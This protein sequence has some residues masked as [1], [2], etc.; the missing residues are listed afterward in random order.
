[1][2]FR[3]VVIAQSAKLDLRMNHLVVRGAEQT[4][5]IHLG[6]IG[7][8]VIESL[9]V[10]LTAALLA[11][12]AEKKIR[13]LFCD[14]QHS[15]LAEL[16]PYYARHDCSRKVRCQTTWREETKA[17]V[18]QRIVQAKIS[19]QADILAACIGED[20][21]VR[22]L[23]EYAAAVQ[24]ADTGGREAVA[25]KIY[26]AALFGPEFTRTQPTAINAGLNYGYTIILSMLN[27]EVKAAG[28]LTEL[29]IF[30]DSQHN[31]F[32]LS[33]DLMEPFRP[34]ADY[35]VKQHIGKEFGVKEK[36]TLQML[37]TLPV[38]LDG[39]RLELAA[40]VRQ[41]TRQICEMLTTDRADTFP[42]LRYEL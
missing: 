1:M 22:Q 26:F 17:L 41:Y 6:E 18:W 31:F 15:P 34:L 24:P 4:T 19:C 33:S 35:C 40:A 30:H 42:A 21:A 23:R 36:R 29:G 12:L 32:N 27:R 5:K 39:R 28:Y 20:S 9:Q 25:A 14:R 13:V 38:S 3:T 37:D 2:N 8:L 7:T 11:E 10:S 16:L